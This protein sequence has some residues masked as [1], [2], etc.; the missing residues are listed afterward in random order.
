MSDVF[1]LPASLQA[2]NR[3]AGSFQ[4]VE[5]TGAHKRQLLARG[6]E[7]AA[8]ARDDTLTAFAKLKTWY[9]AAESEFG[10]KEDAFASLPFRL[11]CRSSET[12]ESIVSFAAVS[13]C[14]RNPEWSLPAG[15]HEAGGRW[16]ISRQILRGVLDRL[17]DHQALWIDQCC[18]LQDDADEKATAVACMDIVFKSAEV[19]FASIEDVELSP[20][21]LEALSYESASIA[22][23]RESSRQ[24]LI[25]ALEKI[26]SSRLLRRA[27][28]YQEAQFSAHVTV[29]VP[30]RSGE[31][32]AYLQAAY[33]HQCLYQVFLE[34]AWPAQYSRAFEFFTYRYDLVGA[35]RSPGIMPNSLMLESTAI[36]SRECSLLEDLINIYLNVTGIQLFHKGASKSRPEFIWLISSV[37]L[38]FGDA[39]VLGGHL[40]YSVNTQP[41]RNSN[42]QET[43]VRWP[44]AGD[45][46]TVST[47]RR[48]AKPDSI[49]RLNEDQI[50]LEMLDLS[51]GVF[52]PPNESLLILAT[53]FLTTVFY[54]LE[55][56]QKQV[57]G[58]P[59]VRAIRRCDNPWAY[60]R[61]LSN[62]LACCLHNGIDWMV[63]QM[64]HLEEF[65]GSL[66][67]LQTLQDVCTETLENMVENLAPDQWR[68]LQLF[69]LIFIFRDSIAVGLF[70]NLRHTDPAK[71]IA[72]RRCMCVSLPKGR[73]AVAVFEGG[74]FKPDM[75]GIP[76]ALNTRACGTLERLWLLD[77]TDGSEGGRWSISG[78]GVLFTLE[79]LSI[80][81]EIVHRKGLRS[82]VGNR[83]HNDSHKVLGEVWLE[84]GHVVAEEQDCLLSE[85]KA[86]VEQWQRTWKQ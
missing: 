74:R 85:D 70:G 59:L 1:E 38:A 75:I 63:Q 19:V 76:I 60:I 8:A 6:L 30:C 5:I 10:L 21:E 4:L 15:Q 86:Q 25:R 36:Y 32:P 68:N 61:Y 29:L 83:R 65:H 56:D 64:A 53:H 72:N 52:K 24:A 78:R 79:S 58:V 23:A 84:H 69:L 2:H 12:P 82:I 66:P 18:I 55:A 26:C 57:E 22:M 50:L 35:S 73:K 54:R 41:F 37:T 7:T 13:Y 62:L 48:T 80:D 16:P 51:P 31:E 77:R 9:P 43:W 17:Q 44:V 46:V 14:W 20:A 33:L 49:A 11:L 28:C 47:R 45:F 40:D 81:S 3:G 39:T 27:W 42:G 67:I 34:G 71:T